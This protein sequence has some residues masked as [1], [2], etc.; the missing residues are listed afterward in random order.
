[1]NFYFTNCG[2]SIQRDLIVKRT[3]HYGDRVFKTAHRTLI[4]RTSDKAEAYTELLNSRGPHQAVQNHCQLDRISG[5]I[6]ALW[7]IASQLNLDW[8][9]A[10]TAARP[11]PMRDRK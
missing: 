5:T 8:K 3:A 1:M 10:V 4:I 9:S 7:R 11:D 6:A 2:K